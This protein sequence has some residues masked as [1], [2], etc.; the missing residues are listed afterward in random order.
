M[1]LKLGNEFGI[2]PRMA[3]VGD[4]EFS[5]DFQD[6]RCKGMMYIFGVDK[7]TGLKEPVQIG[8][9][10]TNDVPASKF[11]DALIRWSEYDGGDTNPVGIDFI[12]KDSG[13]YVIAIYLKPEALLRTMLPER[14]KDKVDPII[15]GCTHFKTVDSGVN[16]NDFKSTY[17][18]G[19][20]IAVGYL[21]G[22]PDKIQKSS[23]K[24]ILK[25]EF[26]FYSEHDYKESY[27]VSL[28]K[29]LS[30]KSEDNKEM[31]FPFEQTDQ[32][33]SE[34]RIKEIK[35]Y[36]P[37]TLNKLANKNWLH[38]ITSKLNNKYD[39]EE[40]IQAVCN[41]I[42]FERMAKSGISEK[43]ISKIGYAVDLIDFLSQ[44][45]ET[46]TSYYP[47]DNFFSSYKVEAQICRDR[48]QRI[49]LLTKKINPNDDSF[50][51]SLC[52]FNC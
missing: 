9:L 25:T 22:D 8:F 10:F 15:M 45:Y 51:L 40:I 38:N 27:P 20:K 18:Q 4:P 29:N 26:G 46:F 7:S 19:Q 21:I 34:R 36:F 31:P 39:K 32:S 50:C 11:L 28:Y 24:Y 48:K 37:V 14:M 2:K 35:E 3:L 52:I 33:V 5:K 13:E 6:A 30:E 17:K 16:Y 42:L 49:S 41:M 44:N 47:P 12:E 23:E 1:A 43:N